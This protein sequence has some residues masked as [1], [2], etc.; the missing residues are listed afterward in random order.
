[1]R[2]LF[3]CSQNRLRSSTA[4]VVFSAV[5]GVEALSAGMDSDA[6]TPISA[7][8]IE[9]AD[10]ILAMERTHYRRLQERF[11]PL[12]KDKR[13][14]VLRIRDEYDYMDPELIRIL[15][16]KVPPLLRLQPHPPL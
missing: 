15:R 1:M 14:S 4:E 11:G 13:I 6:I 3:V 9:W 12:L 16:K 10:L 7:D 8:L 2:V 5:E